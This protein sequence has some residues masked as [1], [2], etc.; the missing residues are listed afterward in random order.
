[1]RKTYELEKLR[2]QEELAEIKEEL[3]QRN[4]ED[5]LEKQRSKEE[6]DKNLETAHY[7]AKCKNKPN[8]KTEKEK[9]EKIVLEILKRN[10]TS[11]TQSHS[12]IEK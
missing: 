12:D 2:S 8:Q 3:E 11:L 10:T 5:E 1:M 6:L 4:K 9:S 7:Q